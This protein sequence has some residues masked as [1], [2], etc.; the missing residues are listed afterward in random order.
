MLE[1][2]T[3]NNKGWKCVCVD[4]IIYSCKCNTHAYQTKSF[5]FNLCTVTTCFRNIYDCKK[6]FQILTTIFANKWQKIKMNCMLG[7]LP[8]LFCTILVLVFYRHFLSFAPFDTN[9]LEKYFSSCEKPDSHFFNNVL[10]AYLVWNIFIN[11]I[12]ISSTFFLSVRVHND[13]AF[14]L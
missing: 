1:W 11:F 13:R 5:K 14:I 10:C 8:V 2:K 6:N 12:K 7:A 9:L 3:Q 4:V